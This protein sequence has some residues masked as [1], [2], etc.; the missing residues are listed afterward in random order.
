MPDNDAIVAVFTDH[1]GAEAATKKLAEG[2]F[3]L[4]K[5]TLVGKGYHSEEKIIGFYNTGDRVRFWGKYGTFWGGLWGLLFGGIF[6]TVSGVGPVVVLGYLAAV[7]LSGIES[8]IVV[9]GVSALGA[10]LYSIGIPKDSVLNYETAVKADGF[11]VMAHGTAEEMARA[12]AIL[13]TS[14]PSRVDVHEDLPEPPPA[15]HSAHA[16]V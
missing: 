9:G 14:N 11:L 5:L 12:K 13:D 8:A 1:Q 10:A 7:I 3:D 2:G 6:V 16:A 4:K 15:D